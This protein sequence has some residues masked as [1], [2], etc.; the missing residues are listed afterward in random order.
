M[1][2]TLLTMKVAE[3]QDL[4]AVRQRTR[5]L[6]SLLG[7][8]GQDQ[9]RLAT[10]VSEICRNAHRYA[11]GG[12]IEFGVEGSTPPQMLVVR[13]ADRGPG[14]AD[15]PAILQG[16][17]RSSTGMGLGI[18]GARRLVDR[19]KID[20]APGQ[21][22][23][24]VMHKLF[25]KRGAALTPAALEKLTRELS[26]STP[27]SAYEELQ[28]QHHELLRTLEELRVRQSELTRLN[29][30]LEDTNRGVVALYAE[31]DE[32]AQRLKQANELKSTFLSHMSHEF[33]TPLN[34]IMALTSILRERLDGPLTT[35]QEKQVN[36]INEAA[37]ELTDLVNDLLDLAKVE[38][39]K[40]E[41]HP[42]EWQV[43]MLF[44]TLRG[45]LRPLLFQQA[46]Q[47]SFD[48]SEDITLYTDEGKVSQILRNFISNAIKFTERGEIR[49]SA[50]RADGAVRFSV[51]DT[52]IGIAPEDQER[53]FQ[54]FAQ[55]DSPKQ[56]RV[57]GTGLG[58][59]LSKKLAELLGGRI[60]L[61][62]ETGAGST[63]SVLVPVRYGELTMP[64][65][66]LAPRAASSGRE[67]Q[68]GGG[69]VLVID[70]DDVA[71]YLVKKQLTELP[72]LVIEAQSA[73]QG[74][75]R[76]RQERPQAI[77]LDLMMPEVS[78]FEALD[79]LKADTRTRDIP[80][81]VHTSMSVPPRD[82][83]LLMEKAVVVLDKNRLESGELKAL[84]ADLV[85]AAP[86]QRAG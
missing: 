36:F 77:I 41:M 23:T 43:S 8:D 17:Y 59:P 20:T 48:Y 86:G 78:G 19:F 70:D 56:R 55:V 18:Q 53:I 57:R 76:A 61:V 67:T 39:G 80:V 34:S 38:A 82:R 45:M 64:D 62:S 46:V 16:R 74:L 58:L 79:E 11:G 63:F 51:T 73:I 32:N 28:T 72:V 47:L 30:E 22:T 6:L 71:R 12:M 3:E 15:L 14:I 75:E 37:Q 26:T 83:V 42:T 35:E 44:G 52:G 40:I 25:P 31:L 5:R 33:R 24:V 9:T 60:E 50:D 54:Q 85:R 69:T 84:V 13:V 21:G 68:E 66:P 29:Q 2:V 27:G 65:Q 4:V 81:V 1:I 49:V 7:F 10:A